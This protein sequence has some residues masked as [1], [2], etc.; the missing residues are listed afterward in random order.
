LVSKFDFV[1]E[2]ITELKSNSLYRSLKTVTTSRTVTAVV[3]GKKAINLCSND[4]LGLSRNRQVVKKTISALQQISQCSSRLIAGNSPK[5]EELEK[6]LAGHRGTESALVYPSG[7]MANLG[8][9]TAIADS[10]STIFSD[11]LSHSSI[12]DGCRISNAT[13]RVFRHNDIDHLKKLIDSSSGKK[14]IVTEGVFSMDGDISNLRQICNIGKDHNAITIIDDAHGDFIFGSSQAFSGVPSY[15]S[16]NDLVDIHISSLS[17]AL[18][19]FGGYVA[20]TLAV[21]EFLV[22]RSRQFIYTSALPEHLCVSALTALP[23][24]TKGN[25]QQR[26]FENIAFFRGRL[27]KIGFMVGQ[28]SSQIIPIL[29]GEEKLAVKISNELL[30]KGI[31]AQAVRYPTVK[32]G[33][34]RLRISLSSLHRKTQLIYTIDCLEKLGKMMKII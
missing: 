28:S 26:L 25:L 16:V 7:Y 8:V 30:T 21:K 34:A 11:E 4:Y 5:F 23:I 31:F 6:Q 13:V 15:L 27:K 14:A 29:I 20:T 10:S 3:N 2:E 12:I 33:S 9:I 18:G 19:C 17:K 22:N 32:K 24:A 1:K